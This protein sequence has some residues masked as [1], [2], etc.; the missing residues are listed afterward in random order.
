LPLVIAF[1]FLAPLAA[2]LFFGRTFCA[3]VCPHGALQDAVIIHP[4]SVPRWLD[5]GLRLVRHVYLVL[6]VVFAANGAM[7]VIC[8]YDPFV[9]IFRLHGPFHMLV[10]G[11]SFL[12]LGLVVARPYCRYLCPYGALLGVCSSLSLRSVKLATG[13]CNSCGLCQGSCPVGALQGPEQDPGPLEG[14]EW[15]RRRV[16]MLGALPVMLGV[17]AGLGYAVGPMLASAHPSVSLLER[18]DQERSG[19]VN[20]TTDASDAFR[21][22]ARGVDVLREESQGIVQ[23]FSVGATAGGTWLGLVAWARLWSLSTSR[24]RMGFHADPAQCLACARCYE[25]CPVERPDAGLVPRSSHEDRG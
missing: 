2:A 15:R 20:G 12:V 3:A 10:F 18:L 24:R 19:L 13:D 17:S 23:G 22:Q 7:F 6:A 8:R 25:S 16:L 4:L 1:F 5:E 9:T 14:S 11:A 21:Q